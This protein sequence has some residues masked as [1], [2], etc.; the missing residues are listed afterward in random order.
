[1]SH[2]KDKIINIKFRELH[3]SLKR[4]NDSQYYDFWKNSICIADDYKFYSD[5]YFCLRQRDE[6]LNLAQIYIALKT[7]CGESNNFID[8]YKGSFSF[9]FLIEVRKAGKKF[10]YLL[11]IYDFRGSLYFGIRKL[12]QFDD[13]YNRGVSYPPF[14]EE[15]SRNEINN[16]VNYFYGYIK[17]FFEAIQ[18][19]YQQFFFK[20]VDSNGILFG[21]KDGKFFEEHYDEPEDYELAVKLLEGGWGG[22]PTTGHQ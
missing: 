20:K 12:L 3:Y 11:D 14:A 13:S 19:N 5:F 2:T 17:G 22:V 10:D 8:K 9:P 6:L 1:M 7:L 4:L 16:F 21:Y 15:F 18:S